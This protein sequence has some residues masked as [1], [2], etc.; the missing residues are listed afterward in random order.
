MTSTTST[1][2][3]P[4][5]RSQRVGSDKEGETTSPSPSVLAGEGTVEKKEEAGTGTDEEAGEVQ[6]QEPANAEYPSGFALGLIV[7]ALVLSIF[8]IALDMTI[9]ATAIPKITDEFKGLDQVSW[10]GAAFFMCVAAFQSTW[11]KAY[12][13]FPL[14]WSFLLSIFI[15]ELGSLICAV[16]PNSVALIVGRAI[17]GVG[18]AGIGSGAYT[19][20]G[21]SAPPDKRPTFTGI[22]GAS[23]GLASVI[24]P[25]IGGAFTDHVSWRWCFYINLPVGG[26]GAAIILFFFHTPPQAVPQKA[27]ALEKFL[28]MDLIGTSLI[29]GGTIAFLLALQWGGSTHPWNSSTIIGLFVGFGLI[30]VAFI[31]LEWYQGE[32]SMI[33]PRLI[34]DRTIY[35]SSAYAFFFAGSYFVLVYYLP[36][37]F[38][39]VDNAT[40]TESGVRNLPIIIAVTIATIASGISISATGIYAPIMV[41]GGAVATVGAGLL[42]TLDIGTGSDKWI[43]YQ[44]LAGLAWGAAFQV[45]I[46]AVQGT[47]SETDM[48]SSTAILLFF[49]TVGGAF[50]VAG[51][52][53]GFLVTVLKKVAVYAPSVDPNLVALTGATEIRNAFPADAVPGIIQAYMDGLKV[54]FAIAIAGAGVSFLISLGSRWGKLNTANLSGAA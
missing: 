1:L 20:I 45:P 11:G 12:K 15:F 44:V 17:A 33:A 43:G 8:L 53:S 10:Y 6:P 2:V 51:A 14:K 22:I 37:Y 54:T 4:R 26:L 50:F 13:Y 35:I 52:Q 18:A 34:K 24:G 38:Q 39:S 19:I 30:I 27:S 25:L 47:V 41:V 49:Q 21:F 28:Q 31:I 32:R 29:M 9:V 3:T 7:F 36:I 16:A 42:Y 40:P 5:D 23:Y 46:I 48:A